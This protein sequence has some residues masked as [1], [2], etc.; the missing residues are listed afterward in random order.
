[1]RR[2]CNGRVVTSALATV[3]TLGLVVSACSSPPQ[4]DIIVGPRLRVSIAAGCPASNA[5]DQGVTNTGA[6]LNQSLLPAGEP[7]AALTCNY[8]GLNGATPFALTSHNLLTQA[9]ARN[10]A[11]LAGQVSL[12]RINGAFSCPNDTGEITVVGF[13]YPKRPDVDLWYHKGGCQW[14]S[15]GKITSGMN[16]VEPF[17]QALAAHR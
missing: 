7:R 9:A 1:M 12:S 17:A 11:T 5:Q 10:L 14:L 3:V 6:D 13:S 16:N 2:S 15:N 8:S 4:P